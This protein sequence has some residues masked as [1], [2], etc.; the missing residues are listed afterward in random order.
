M[1]IV[2]L[3]VAL[4]VLHSSFAQMRYVDSV[5]SDIQSEARVYFDKINEQLELDIFFPEKDTLKDRPLLLYVH[6][7]GF[8]GG[9]RDHPDQLAFCE[10][11]AKKG[12]VTA[13]MSYTLQRKGKSFGCDCPS[14]E[15]IQTFLL[16]A[17]DISRATQFLI[18]NSKKY[19]IDS[20]KI[21]LLGSSA[22]AEAILHAAYWKE[23]YTDIEGL[24]LPGSFKYAGVVSMAGAITFDEWI[25]GD[26]AIPTQLFHGT[27]DDLVPYG[28][29][30]HHYCAPETP[31][32]LM[33]HGAYA[34]AERLRKLGKGFYLVTGCYGK[35][36][37]NATPLTQHM[38]R[39]TDFIYH[40][41]L[42]GEK[43]QIHE[44]LGSQY[45][46]PCTSHNTFSFCEN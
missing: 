1:R 22:G 36:E 14:P 25:T 6:G 37:W 43:R 39:I 44:I 34:I 9:E 3:L 23:T 21:V 16:T 11:M 8:S 42:I 33:L 30:P 32:Y 13:T 46:E 18:N 27:C 2:I 17:Q 7:G 24:I 12:Y 15:K 35:H 26:S 31:G 20:T 28:Y 29:A 5:F 40:D 4:L 19:G 45:N 38:D 41:I 10:K